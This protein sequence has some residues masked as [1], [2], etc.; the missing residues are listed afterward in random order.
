MRKAVTLRNTDRGQAATCRLDGPF[1][2][3]TGENGEGNPE[4]LTIPARGEVTVDAAALRCEDVRRRLKP[5]GPLQVLR[6]F[7]PLPGDPRPLFDLS[8]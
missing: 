8:R 2:S 5:A 6:E 4:T 3:L 1:L 7:V